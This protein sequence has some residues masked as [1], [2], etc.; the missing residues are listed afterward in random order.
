MMPGCRMRQS[1]VQKRSGGDRA[2]PPLSHRRLDR[3]GTAG[4]G[5]DGIAAQAADS[6]R[7]AEPALLPAW[8]Y[9]VLE[10]VSGAIVAQLE[11]K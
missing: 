11:S 2:Q 4:D 7:V 1:L 3:A 5:A 10:H 9:N 6:A 8:I